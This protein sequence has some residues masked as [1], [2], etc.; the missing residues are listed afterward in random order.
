[1]TDEVLSS[2]DERALVE[3]LTGEVLRDVAPEEIPTYEADR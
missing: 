3:A 2:S 1:M